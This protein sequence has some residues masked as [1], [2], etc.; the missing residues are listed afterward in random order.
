VRYDFKLSNKINGKLG[1]S[2]LNLYNKKNI[3]SKDYT[4][5]ED[6]GDAINTASLKEINRYSLART[7]NVFFRITF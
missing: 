2:L 3:L 1:F 5:I 4:L 6:K 7:P